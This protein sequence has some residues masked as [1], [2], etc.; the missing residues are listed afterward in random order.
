MIHKSHTGRDIADAVDYYKAISPKLAKQFLS[1][2]DEALD[3]IDEI[4]L[5]YQ[6]KYNNVRTLMLKQFPYKIHYL[7]DDR[8][9]QIV[10]LAIIHSNKNPTDYSA[11]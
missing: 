3:Q 11:R 4:P 6:A 7:I 2:L 10:I 1:R 8:N 5:G 9:S